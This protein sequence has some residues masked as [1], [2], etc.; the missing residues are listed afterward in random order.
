MISF[1]HHW[2]LV[3]WKKEPLSY[4]ATGWVALGVAIAGGSTFNGFAKV[5]TGALSPFTLLVLSEMLT[6]TFLTLTF[7]LLPTVRKL[8]AVN[9]RQIFPLVLM[10]ICSGI[11]GPLLW[12][13]GLEYTE[14]VNAS[15][16]GKMEVVFL[17]VMAH[18]LLRECF[19]RG[20]ALA[21]ATV[22]AG[23]VTIVFQGFTQTLSVQ[24]GDLLILVAAF[25][26]S[27]GNILFRK[28]FVDIAPEAVL[29]WRC[30][31]A[32]A[33]FFLV[34][35]F[36]T[37][38]FIEEVKAFPMAL[39]PAV[40]GFGFLSRFLNSFSF[41]E[42]IERLPVS[43]VS[44][45][46]TLEIIGGALFAYLYVGEP[47]EWYHFAGGGLILCGTVLLELAGTTCAV[48]SVGRQTVAP[49]DTRGTVVG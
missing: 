35:P 26:Y 7:G 29:F 32:I 27:L 38:P 1:T 21:S 44:L 12:F 9:R 5:L 22:V 13:T 16:F 18:L 10:G 36:T 45:V 17:I 40:I 24:P 14:A 31:T 48:P 3:R 23:V 4:T 28:Y 11:F 42:A 47:L 43:T 8:A 49:G 2:P 19:T 37:H 39:V 15:F 6:L 34:S 46:G 30:C 20:H 33:A 41:Y 25:C